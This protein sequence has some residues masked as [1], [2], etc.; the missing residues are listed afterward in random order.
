[1]GE[2]PARDGQDAPFAD[3]QPFATLDTENSLDEASLAQQV[4]ISRR[5][6][7]AGDVI[8]GKYRIEQ[9]LGRGGMGAVFSAMH[10]FTDK[11]VAIK[12]MLPSTDEK[13]HKRFIREAKAAGRIDHPNVVDVYDIGLEADYSYLVMEMLRGESLRKRLERERLAV[14]ECI[15]LLMPALRGVAAVH[16]AGVVHRDLKP[17]NIFLC[18]SMHGQLPEA[19]VLDFGISAINS[20]TASDSKLTGVGALLGTPAYMSPEQLRDSGS[21]DPRSDVYAFGVIL[22]E[23]LT[24]IKPFTADSIGGLV[25]AIV[26][27]DPM[28]PCAVRREI[29]RALAEIILRAMAKQRDARWPDIESLMAALAPFAPGYVSQQAIREQQPVAR[30]RSA[31]GLFGA[32]FVLAL[33]LAAVWWWQSAPAANNRAASP[34][35]EAIVRPAAPRDPVEPVPPQAAR[36]AASAAELAHE[37][38]HGQDPREAQPSPTVPSATTPIDRGGGHKPAPQ[39][40]R[41]RTSSRASG[42]SMLATPSQ[43]SAAAQPSAEP[44]KSGASKRTQAEPPVAPGRSGRIDM[45][46]L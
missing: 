2:K 38:P 12:W 27:D 22:Y 10:L 31:S 39:G 1:M 14:P 35:R 7:R 29:P 13:S 5:L 33:A 43:P 18:D 28:H 42:P 24:G 3:T 15:A 45:D 25:L 6:P 23:A 34:A 46:D 32:A 44:P 16:Q 20:S 9:C 40:A 26:Q 37:L 41:P 36:E 17:D 11:H 4:L 19:K 30:P 21:V 8:A